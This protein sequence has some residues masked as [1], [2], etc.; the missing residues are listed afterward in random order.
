MCYIQ[1]Q[2]TEV[3]HL[4]KKTQ[5]MQSEWVELPSLIVGGYLNGTGLI[6]KI[7][8][9]LA[10]KYLPHVTA[11]EYTQRYS[12]MMIVLNYK[13][14]KYLIKVSVSPMMP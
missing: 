2:A 1:M 9:T 11:N 7:T 6:E 4:R 8:W 5:R 13:F 12:L 14:P 3:E 10:D